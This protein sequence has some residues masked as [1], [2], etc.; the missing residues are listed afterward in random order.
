MPA[1]PLPSVRSFLALAIGAGLLDC[2]G[3]SAGPKLSANK[4]T[5]QRYM[6]AFTRTDHPAILACLTNDVE[7]LIPGAFHL[8]GKAAFDKEIENDAFVG[9]PDI[10]VTRLTEERDV[11]IAEGSVRSMRKDGRP[12]NLLFCDVFV[13]KH[14]KI[15]KLTSYL[16]EVKK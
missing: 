7:W 2:S 13:M 15:R 8:R 9:K 5:V 1:S 3:A 16:V 4:Q 11:V 6:E 10:R 12:L 14:G